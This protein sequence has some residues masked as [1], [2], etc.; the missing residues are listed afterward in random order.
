MD[1]SARRGAIYMSMGPSGAGKDTLLLGV[2]K[3][4]QSVGDTRVE[5]RA[6]R[7]SNMRRGLGE[8]AAA[9]SPRAHHSS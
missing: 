4:L 9:S 5:V 1:A 2:R 3:A 7:A 6:A 8:Y